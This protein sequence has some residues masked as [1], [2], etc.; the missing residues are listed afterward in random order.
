VQKA[1]VQT[2]LLYSGLR[3]HQN[4]GGWV[5]GTPVPGIAVPGAEAFRSGAA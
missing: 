1:V 5:A 2:P 3:Y 4:L